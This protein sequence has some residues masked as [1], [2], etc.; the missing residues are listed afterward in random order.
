MRLFLWGCTGSVRWCVRGY[1]VRLCGCFLR[2]FVCCRVGVWLSVRD[3]FQLYWV[4][5]S[6]FVVRLSLVDSVPRRGVRGVARV[7]GRSG[8]GF[9]HL[10]FI[11]VGNAIGGVMVPFGPK[12]SVG[13]LF[14]RN[15]LFSKSSVTKFIKVG[16]DS[17]ILGPSVGACSELS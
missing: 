10:R 9:V 4:G 5:R 15:V 12:S 13:R 1:V 17:L 14:G 7:V 3:V 11:S 6:W 2:V 16:S 8:V